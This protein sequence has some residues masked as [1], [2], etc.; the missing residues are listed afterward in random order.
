MPIKGI[1]KLYLFAKIAHEKINRDQSSKLGLSPD[2]V[3]VVYHS[4]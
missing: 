1:D 2:L 3:N 4:Y